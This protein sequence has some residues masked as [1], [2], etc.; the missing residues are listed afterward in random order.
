MEDVNGFYLIGRLT[1]DA[2]LKY[3]NAG[4]AVSTFSLAV[5]KRKKQGEDY[6]E[7][8]HFFDMALFGQKAENLNQYLVKG[9]QFHAMGKL[10]QDRWEQDGA[11]RSKTALECWNIQLLGGGR[12]ENDIL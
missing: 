10:K 1:R 7:E 6:I 11:K 5:T 2:E 4:V 8:P 9:K 3:T 12:T